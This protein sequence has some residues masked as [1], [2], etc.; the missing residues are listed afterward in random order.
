[1]GRNIQGEQSIEE[2]NIKS[3]KHL[4]RYLLKEWNLCVP[5]MDSDTREMGYN[6]SKH[7][8]NSIP[9]NEY[10]DKSI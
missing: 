8:K 6:I 3:I 9:Y 1:M 10:K 4:K 2:N 5:G 7:Q